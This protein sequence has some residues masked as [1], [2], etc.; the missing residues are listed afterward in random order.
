MVAGATSERLQKVLAR[1]GIASRRN[2]EKLILQG[3]V[4]VNGLRILELGTKVDPTKD[5]IKVNG[6]LIFTEVEPIYLALNK[7]AGVISA[8][9]DPENRPHLGQLLFGITEKLLT[10]GRMDFTS[11]GLLLLTNDGELLNKIQ[12]KKNLVKTYDVKV[13][14][15]PTLEEIA[16]LKKG[17]F[18]EDGV[19]LFENI[20]VKEKLQNK[21]WLSLHV[22][23]GSHLNLRELLNHRGFL[24]DRIVRSKIGD[25]SIKGLAPGEYKLLKRANFE[26][27]LEES[28]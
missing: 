19:V 3:A 17:I 15:H 10:V 9:S 7:P 14:G 8:F 5:K 21:T 16:R 24:V 1:A 13:K 26:S 27:L 23:Q 2:A 12:K 4:S 18:S 28:K 22:K 25:L 6:K 20:Q 11:E